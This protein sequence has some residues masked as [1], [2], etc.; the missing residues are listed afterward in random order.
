MTTPRH[1]V[2]YVVTEF[3]VANLGMLTARQRR[4][5]LI[6]IAHPEFRAALRGGAR[7]VVCAPLAGGRCE[8][9]GSH[10]AGNAVAQ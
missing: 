7:Q 2:Q 6:E 1:H 5:A 3:G 4:A 10:S 9:P 8:P